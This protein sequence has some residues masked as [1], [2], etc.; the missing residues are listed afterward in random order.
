[1]KTAD[2][3]TQK[4]RRLRSSSQKKANIYRLLLQ[5]L[6]E[7]VNSVCASKLR[8]RRSSI[9]SLIHASL[10]F[11]GVLSQPAHPKQTCRSR[12]VRAP[13]TDPWLILQPRRGFGADESPLTS[14]P[15]SLANLKATPV[16]FFLRNSLWCPYVFPCTRHSPHGPA[17]PRP[18]SG[19]RERRASKGPGG[20]GARFR[21]RPHVV[22]I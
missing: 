4:P 20:A 18:R 7:K 9:Q 13:S 17:R 5:L 14:P 10:L 1:M 19:G 15:C 16:V 6:L 11:K 12:L 21:A 8:H 2:S 3:S 22:M